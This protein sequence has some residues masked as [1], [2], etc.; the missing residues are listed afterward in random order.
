MTLP[1]LPS[2][3][4]LML[5]VT[6]LTYMFSDTTESGIYSI[7]HQ[8]RYWLGVRYNDQSKAY[9]TNELAKGLLCPFCVSLWIGFLVA[10]LYSIAP[11]MI[12]LVLLPFALS[13]VA[14]LAGGNKH[15]K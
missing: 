3:M 12:T 4:I 14:I 5:G 7:L 1:S 11:D 15:A 9:G 8:V 13:E 10:A 2:L 6:R